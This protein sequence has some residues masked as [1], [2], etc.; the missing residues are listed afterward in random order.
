MKFE[1]LADLDDAPAE[2]VVTFDGC[3]ALGA[4]NLRGSGYTARDVVPH[5]LTARIGG[6]LHRAEVNIA[7]LAGFLLA[8][9]AAAHSRRLPKDWYDVAFVLLHNDHGG[10]EGAAEAVRA[11][12]HPDLTGRM[13]TALE[14]LRANFV[15]PTAQGP[16]AYADQMLIDHPG[17]DAVTIA[18]DA[19]L[20]V[21][22]FCGAVASG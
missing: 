2:S 4:V 20:A 1:L 17:L 13:R 10:P 6:V 9:T 22:R 15:V 11:R 7:G 19:V 5:T 3:E 14:D 16:R 21:E 8:K 18:T 12:F